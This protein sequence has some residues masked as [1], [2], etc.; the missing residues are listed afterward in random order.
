VLAVDQLDLQGGKPALVGGDVG[1]V[2]APGHVDLLGVKQ[3][4]KQVRNGRGGLVVL[5]EAAASAA[6]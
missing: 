5:G 3:S 1:Q 4:T 2:A 6:R